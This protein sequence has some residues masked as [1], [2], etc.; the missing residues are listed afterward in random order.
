VHLSDAQASRYHA[1]IRP[2]PEGH[3]LVDL[4]STNGTLLNGLAIREHVLTPGDVIT[5]GT[6]DLRYEEA[7]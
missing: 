7:P 3:V 5:I 1:E 4:G 2:V 6:T